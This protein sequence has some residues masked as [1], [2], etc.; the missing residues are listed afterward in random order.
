[1]RY[2]AKGA[3]TAD[4]QATHLGTHCTTERV[5]SRPNTAYQGVDRDRGH[6]TVLPKDVSRTPPGI[7]VARSAGRR[8][9]LAQA[10]R[11]YYYFE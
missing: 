10:L 2:F 11:P 4:G 5:Y 9:K 7:P 8:S 1:M 3:C 6:S